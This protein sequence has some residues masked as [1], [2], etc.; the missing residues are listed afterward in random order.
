MYILTRTF[1]GM[2]NV[3]V[4]ERLRAA[5]AELESL[6]ALPAHD[7]WQRAR[8]DTQPGFTM[9]EGLRN[10][11]AEFKEVE[12]RVRDLEAEA[13]RAPL[14][15]SSPGI[16]REELRRALLKDLPHV[17]RAEVFTGKDGA[18]KTSMKRHGDILSDVAVDLLKA[19]KLLPRSE[20]ASLATLPPEHDELRRSIV[21]ANDA[22][23]AGEALIRKLS[24]D[25]VWAAQYGWAF[26]EDMQVP[27]ADEGLADE[28]KKRFK[29][30]VEQRRRE[31]REAKAA[32]PAKR[33][34]G[35]ERDLKGQ[36]W[37]TS[38]WPNQPGWH[39]PPGVLS[40]PPGMGPYPGYQGPFPPAQG[41]REG[42]NGA[43]PKGAGKW[44]GR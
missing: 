11:G 15:G 27:A 41:Q 25:I 28:A 9:P 18:P 40:A 36:G 17:Q 23:D 1:V 4:T 8:F 31:E 2:A 29:E 10:F 38:R 35:R 44:H 5:S 24:R 39:H 32:R 21:A 13:C 42:A 34:K 20:D 16:S 33:A 6:R 7:Q 19:R 22:L 30:L 12:R 14:G 37:R 26:V 3:S 43:Y